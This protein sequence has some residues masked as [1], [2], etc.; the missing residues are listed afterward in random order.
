M[1]WNDSDHSRIV[2]PLGKHDSCHIGSM[3]SINGIPPLI[4]RSLSK[5]FSIRVPVI[6]TVGYIIVIDIDSGIHNAHVNNTFGPI[7]GWNWNGLIGLCHGDSVGFDFGQISFVVVF[8]GCTGCCCCVQSSVHSGR[9]S[10][11]NFKVFFD[12]TK[13]RILLHCFIFRTSHLHGQSIGILKLIGNLGFGVPISSLHSLLAN[14]IGFVL[15]VS[16]A[17]HD[18]DHFFILFT[19]VLLCCF[20]NLGAIHTTKHTKELSIGQM[21]SY[22]TA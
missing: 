21:R 10:H 9:R 11:S 19:I 20:G 16:K 1:L 15:G 6:P 8:H 3:R 14:V 12:L 4:T 13:G 22:Q 18:L 17:N 7:G 2:T 5:L